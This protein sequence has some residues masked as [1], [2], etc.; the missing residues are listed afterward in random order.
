MMEITDHYNYF[1]D[2]NLQSIE[3]PYNKESFSALV[4]LPKKNLNI[5][6][7]VEKN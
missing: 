4:I 6:I 1:E 2:A 7:I 5:I 3:L